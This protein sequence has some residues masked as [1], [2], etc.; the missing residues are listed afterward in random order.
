M[1]PLRR[2]RG[3]AFRL[4]PSIAV[5][6][7]LETGLRVLDLPGFDACWYPREFW[8]PEPDPELGW[9]F[10]PGSRIGDATINERGMRGPV[11]P[12]EKLPGHYRI[13]FVGDSTCFGLGIPL[14]ESFPA[15]A[16]RLVQADRPDEVVEFEIAA[17]PGYSSHHSR[18]ITRRMLAQQP[19]LVVFYVG[20]HN[21]HSRARYYPDGDI[22]ERVARR[23]APW[24]RL[25]TALLLENLSDLGY[26]HLVRRFQTH[27]ARARVPPW[28]F[29]ENVREMVKLVRATGA[30]PLVL[31]PPF[32]A[33]LREDHPIIP[34]Y[35]EALREVA[36]E[37]GARFL[38]LQ[39][40]F[41]AR[42]EDE[43]YR[44]DKFHFTAAGHALAA[45][46]VARAAR[47]GP[48]IAAIRR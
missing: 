8:Q 13:L 11:L 37:E 5:L 15:S 10:Q 46:A 19:D 40:L 34:Q 7:L 18:V 20:G 2:L 44:P 14:E 32:S 42:S 16:S 23:Q 28:T 29:R 48:E 41:L 30:V 6:G 39:P 27:A 38:D 43:V 24:H 17:L 45:S 4:L 33:F 3:L 21:D 31:S 22:P 26:R 47:E 35:Q 9:L 25:R 12:R 1:P 36:R